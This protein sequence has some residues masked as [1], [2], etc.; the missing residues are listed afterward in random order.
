MAQALDRLTKESSVSEDEDLVAPEVDRVIKTL[1]IR[2]C[3]R[4]PIVEE[5]SEESSSDDDVAS[6][7]RE[8]HCSVYGLRGAITNKESKVRFAPRS[9][10]NR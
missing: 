10:L 8:R 9:V 7:I 3:R 6:P 5:S 4:P 2:A 1:P